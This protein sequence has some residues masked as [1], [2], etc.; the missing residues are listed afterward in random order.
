MGVLTNAYIQEVDALNKLRRLKE[1]SFYKVHKQSNVSIQQ[2]QNFFEL[3]TEI[4]LC[5][6]LKIKNC[7][8]D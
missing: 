5:T 2:V 6:Y 3:R 4:G 8:K 1:W 7:L